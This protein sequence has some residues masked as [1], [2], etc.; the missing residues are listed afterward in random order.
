[1]NSNGVHL[2]LDDYPATLDHPAPLD[3]LAAFAGDRGDVSFDQLGYEVTKH[4]A[5]VDWNTLK[6]APLPA[7]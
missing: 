3:W 1:M 6:A 7:N 2:H 5:R 4:G